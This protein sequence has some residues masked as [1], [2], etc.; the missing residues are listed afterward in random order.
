MLNKLVLGTRPD[1][2]VTKTNLSQWHSIA[3]FSKKIILAE[4]WYET[5][6]GE[7]LTIVKAF[8]MWHHYFEDCKYEVLILINHNNLRC[9]MDTKS[10]SSRQVRWA[11]KHS[12]YYSWI[13]HGQSNV[14][15]AADTLS[16]FFQKSQ[17]GE[18]KI[19]A[20]NGQIFYCLQNS[21][22]NACLA[23]LIFFSLS[24]LPTYLHQVFI[25]GTYVL[26][27][28]K[29]FWS[30]FRSELSSK[31]SYTAS[32]GNMRLRLYKLQTKNK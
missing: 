22:I 24:S 6:N 23:G 14:N 11:Q 17:N 1:R 10:L 4:T 25:C 7:L 5:N 28:L 13:D 31:G 21:L 9:F 2:A 20:E 27:E 8:K 32:F 16:R 19:R 30:I 15:A 12:Q 26:L 29:E 3:F 18:D